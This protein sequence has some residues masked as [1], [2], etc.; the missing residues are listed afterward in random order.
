MDSPFSLIRQNDGWYV[1]EALS[2]GG[3]LRTGPVVSKVAARLLLREAEARR[4]KMIASIIDSFV[5]EPPLN[6]LEHLRLGHRP[7]DT[8]ALAAG[9]ELLGKTAW[10]W[11]EVGSEP[12]EQGQHVEPLG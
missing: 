2:M 12:S 1:E 7:P 3:T 4:K 11:Y 10:S 9:P 5:R 8:F 6:I